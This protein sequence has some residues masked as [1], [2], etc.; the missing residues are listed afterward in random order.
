MEFNNYDIEN[1]YDESH[2]EAYDRIRFLF[3]KINPKLNNKKYI[4]S[5]GYL[6][7]LMLK[8]IDKTENTYA[9]DI[10]LFFEN[11]KD[12]NEFKNELDSINNEAEPPYE[13]SN[14]VTY[15]FLNTDVA[16]DWVASEPLKI[17]IVRSYFGTKDKIAKKFDLQ[18]CQVALDNFGNLT[19]NKDFENLFFSKEIRLNPERIKD[20]LKNQGKDYLFVVAA[21]ISKYISRYKLK[22]INKQTYDLI[23]EIEKKYYKDLNSH[24]KDI[25]V[26]TDY[27]GEM[28][29]YSVDLKHAWTRNTLFLIENYVDINNTKID[30]P[31]TYKVKNESIVL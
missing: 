22:N 28:Q 16:I 23:S 12:F 20:C 26:H 17:Q 24:Y 29:K 30:W 6:V 25:E 10:D 11:E 1:P 3:N 19:M 21:R 13:T 31:L 9:G 7:Y 18:N 27:S 15:N 4:L 14:A 5:G 8:N 2:I